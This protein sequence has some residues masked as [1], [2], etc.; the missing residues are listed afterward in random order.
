MNLQRFKSTDN[1]AAYK[2]YLNSSIKY[3][4][5]AFTAE[6]KRQFPD[7]DADK[8]D[9]NDPKYAPI[10]KE[11]AFR[12]AISGSLAHSLGIAD[13]VLTEDMWNDIFN[14]WVK[15]ELLP[16]HS[17]LRAYAEET[18]R[19][20]MIKLSNNPSKFDEKGEYVYDGLRRPTSE[21]LFTY[22]K[23]LSIYLVAKEIEEPGTLKEV[24]EMHN[25]IMRDI[26]IPEI[27]KHARIRIQSEGET[28]EDDGYEIMVISI[29]HC[30]S[31]ALDPHIHFHD[32]LVNTAMRK[33]GRLS[34]LHTDLI[35]ENKSHYESLYMGA[36][37]GWMEK[38]HH[39]KFKPTYLKADA[40]N[41]YLEDDEKNIASFD[42]TEDIVPQELV[43]FYMKRTQEMEAALKEK[44]LAK[45]SESMMVEQVSTRDDKSELSPS[46][47]LARWKE[48]FAEL[49]YSAKSIVAST[50]KK[51]NYI[52]ITDRQVSKNFQRKHFEQTRNRALMANELKVAKNRVEAGDDDIAQEHEVL[53]NRHV[54]IKQKV[55][56]D[57]FDEK[58]ITAFHNKTGRIDFKLSQFTAHV[59]KQ[60]LAT[61]SN[62]VALAEADRIA[63]EQLL[64]YIPKERADYFQ[65]FIDGKITEPALKKKMT[66][67]FEKEAVFIT[68]DVKMKSNYIGESLMARKD[69]DRWMVSEEIINEEIMKFEA[70]A[71]YMLS[72][73]QVAAVRAPFREKGAVVNTA[74]MAGAGK[75]TA[76][77][78]IV[79]ICERVGFEPYGTSIANTATKGLAKDA[80]LQKGQ[81]NNSAKLLKLLD[82][83][84]I[85]WN[86]KTFL[87]FDE[88]GMADLDTL[89]RLIQHANKAGAKINF[90]GEKEQL[91]PIGLANGFKYL[92]ENFTTVPLTSI[93]RQKKIEHRENVKLFQK[94]EAKLAVEQLCDEGHVLFTDTISE[95]FEVAAEVYVKNDHL[96]PEDKI[97]M[98]ALNGDNDTIN[99]HIK[100][101]L[102]EK[103]ELDNKTEQFTL[104]CIDGVERE[105]GKGDRIAIF[106]NTKTDDYAPDG[107]SRGQVDNSDPGYIKYVKTNPRTGKPIAF[108]LEMDKIDPATGEKEIRFI[109]TDKLV[110]FRHGWAGTISKAQGASKTKAWQVVSSSARDAHAQYVA[111]SRHKEEYTMILPKEF[112]DK[113]IK[114]LRDRAPLER[115]KSKLQ[116]LKE[117]KG[118]DIPEV[119]FESYGNARLCL[120][121]YIDIQMPGNKTHKMDDFSEIVDQWSNMTFKKN[122][123]DFTEVKPGLKLL[124]DI[125]KERE[126]DIEIFKAT[127]GSIKPVEKVSTPIHLRNKKAQAATKDIPIVSAKQEKDKPVL[128]K[129]EQLSNQ[130]EKSEAVQV[131]P[132]AKPKSKKKGLTLAK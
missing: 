61:C 23:G 69:E 30:E 42:V 10:L 90:I 75:S 22:G 55:L 107:Q 131:K 51:L 70:E 33:D 129:A 34:A 52:P 54:Q 60:A 71:G 93:N 111:A 62:E 84:K 25:Q 27:E 5:T 108:C 101:K 15:T 50:Q 64:L 73:D 1:S 89:F 76:V 49:G 120:Q 67:E 127:R 40:E 104:K 124:R 56:A 96:K 59:V 7:V 3:M 19:G 88:A 105:F 66:F 20:S 94:G 29:P 80:G 18:P 87:Q 81:F 45:T 126:Q 48:E 114:K 78:V 128:T 121:Q 44:G 95:A 85:I 119:A 46:E 106:K 14:G 6:V 109:G 77:K 26:I 13:K 112:M 41:E 2:N 57:S 38:R 63:E 74:G 117:V 92:N 79:R 86:E 65:P 91:E 39:L 32:Q 37:M 16:E 58:V 4:L 132:T 102:Q 35:Y 12:P 116:W 100:R 110:P 83:R 9:Y 98:S 47:L 28:I 122:V 31:R 123:S 24:Q 130:I 118:I 17:H 36:M 99:K 103:G 97:M 11:I 113:E 21:A 72:P 115:Q 43:D 8:I 53:L 125:Q 82:E 68:R